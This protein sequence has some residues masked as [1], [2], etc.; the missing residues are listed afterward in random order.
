MVECNL[1]RVEVAGSS[2]VAC[3]KLDVAGSIPV[4]RSKPTEPW[5]EAHPGRPH[6]CGGDV[7]YND[8]FDAYFCPACDLWLTDP[9][10][11]TDH[12]HC[13]YDCWLRPSKPSEM[14]LE[15]LKPETGL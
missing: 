5:S 15:Q 7:D 14:T 8:F 1:P 12:S 4:V 11:A 13:G 2:P 10:G 9:C 6:S 3:S